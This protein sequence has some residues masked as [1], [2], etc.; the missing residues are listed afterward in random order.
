MLLQDVHPEA[1]DAVAAWV[2][3]PLLDIVGTHKGDFATLQCTATP[4]VSHTELDG[5]VDAVLKKMG[6]H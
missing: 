3:Q 1:Q 6:I 4:H 2:S 5:N